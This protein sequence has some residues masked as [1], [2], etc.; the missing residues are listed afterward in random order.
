MRGVRGGAA[1]LGA[2]LALAGC[3]TDITGSQEGQEEVIEETTFAPSLGIDLSRMTRLPSGVYIEDLVEG[4]GEGLALGNT[5]RLSFTGWLRTGVQ[6]TQGEVR[7]F[8]GNSEV[9]AGYELG[10]MGMKAGG[11]RRIVIPPVL[12]F[13]PAGSGT[14]PP[15]AIVVYRTTLLEIVS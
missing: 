2:I 6:F 7:F 9:I 4:T 3:G 1:I 15:G 10:V 14:V 5:A 13:G 11:V 8:L 12:A